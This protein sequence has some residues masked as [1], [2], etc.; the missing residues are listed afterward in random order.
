MRSSRLHTIHASV[1]TLRPFLGRGSTPSDLSQGVPYLVTYPMTHLMLPTTHPCG[2]TD[3]TFPQLPTYV[4]YV[5]FNSVSLAITLLGN[6]AEIYI[7]GTQYW[8][9]WIG[10]AMLIPMAAHIFIPV[11]FRLQLTSVF[12]VR[13]LS[14]F[15]WLDFF[16]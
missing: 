7:Y 10:Y 13:N 12:E 15:R 9:I 1:A 8:M 4:M 11:F 14:T 6:P 5:F 3:I 2:P 16:R